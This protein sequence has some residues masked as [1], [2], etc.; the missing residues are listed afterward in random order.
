MRVF[1][2]AIIGAFALSGCATQIMSE[3]ECFAADW[4]GA[5]IQDGAQGLTGAAFEARAAQC[6]EFGAPPPDATAYREGRK[7]ALFQ[8][9]TD[10]GGYDFGRSG[11]LYRG[12]CLPEREL[13]FLGGY[14]SGRRIYGFQTSRDEAQ[15][16][17]NAAVGAVDYRRDLI[18]RARKTLRDDD[19]TEKEIEDAK[20][21]IEYA[22]DGLP[23]LERQA[24]DTLYALGRA[25]EAFSQALASAESWR[26]SEAFQQA[27]EILMDAH[28]FARAVDAVDFC[29][30]RLPFFSPSCYLR[31]GAPVADMRTGE[32]CVV[33][34]GEAVL[35]MRAP[36]S[37]EGEPGDL[38]LVFDYFPEG[39]SGGLFQSR[40]PEGR[41]EVYVDETGEFQRTACPYAAPRF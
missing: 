25:D 4:Y 13:D 12:V 2:T 15:S 6:A 10:S 18:R 26:G 28:G 37:P 14:I 16:Q 39:S 11:K 7:L 27:F 30:D 34:P 40:R 33:G 20:D 32:V 31:P 24:E 1:L 19:A 8:L 3:Q 5:G 23:Y 22:R 21:N 35:D 17:Y 29:T 9:C 38:V 41:F 36:L